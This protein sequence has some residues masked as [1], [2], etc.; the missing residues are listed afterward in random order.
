[1]HQGQL[2]LRVLQAQAKGL[3]SKKHFIKQSAFLSSPQS[4]SQSNV[5]T[6]LFLTQSCPY[7]FLLFTINF[8]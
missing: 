6:A 3:D 2:N 1:M 8:L 5:I 7:T 4:H